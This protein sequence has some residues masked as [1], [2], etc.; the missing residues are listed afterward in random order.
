MTKDSIPSAREVLSGETTVYLATLDGDQ[1]RVR[2]VTLVEHQGE[3]F[4]LTGTKNAK[5]IQIRKHEKAEIVA[6]LR[7]EKGT[8]YVRFT[9]LVTVEKDPEQRTRVAKAA[10][11][12]SD[13]WDSPEHPEYA[14]LRIQ[15]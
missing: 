4:V 10:S 8:G 9:A 7:H 15:R 5:V 13:F 6:P 3:F 2:P 14:L 1:P 12:F 11:F